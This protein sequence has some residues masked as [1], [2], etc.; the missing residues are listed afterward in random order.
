MASPRRKTQPLP[1]RVASRLLGGY[2]WLVRH[3]GREEIIGRDEAEA[4]HRRGKGLIFAFWHNRLALAPCLLNRAPAPVHMLV[5]ANRDGDTITAGIKL[6]RLHFIRGSAANPR[7]T[8]K[9]KGGATALYQMIDILA[10]GDLVGITP[11]GP[12][13][14]TERVQP[15]VIR[16]AALSGAPIIPAGFA[17]KRTL[18]LNTWDRFQV[19]VPF[20]AKIFV[21]GD[22]ITVPENAD[23]AALEAA[24]LSLETALQAV[25]A[26]ADR[27]LGKNCSTRPE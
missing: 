5:S 13:G 14:P 21:A 8:F 2:V 16:L 4:A 6:D 10:Q 24:R 1:R 12:R 3:T 7:K 20:A 9:G 19:A 23:A 25:S 27:R 15:G 17:A 18:R 26:E 11:D 22:P